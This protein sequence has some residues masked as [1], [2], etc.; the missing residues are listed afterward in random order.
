VL[1][2]HDGNVRV[3]D[4]GSVQEGLT[5]LRDVT[6]RSKAEETIGKVS[7]RYLW[8]SKTFKWLLLYTV[9]ILFP[10]DWCIRQLC[11]SSIIS[12]NITSI[13]HNH[14]TNI[15]LFITGINT[16]VSFPR[17]GRLIYEKC[18]H[19]ENRYL[20]FRLRII[21]PVFLPAPLSRGGFSRDFEWNHGGKF[22]F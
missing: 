13:T 3:C 14:H 6:E 4:F 1:L 22:D 20:G 19:W 10:I 17:D 15:P 5:P 8:L 18:S 11:F 12:Y 21:H 16:C 9:G 7:L 2:G